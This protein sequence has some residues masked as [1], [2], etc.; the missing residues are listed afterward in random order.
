[1]NCN[2]MKQLFNDGC[3]LPRCTFPKG[4]TFNATALVVNEI[5]M[6]NCIMLSKEINRSCN[7]INNQPNIEQFNDTLTR[8]SL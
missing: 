8:V 3:K 7:S 4:W 2:E 5:Q 6:T 1:M